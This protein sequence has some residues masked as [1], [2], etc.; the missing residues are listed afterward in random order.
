LAARPA[1]Y[2]PASL[3]T[4]PYASAP[5]T[6][7]HP[8]REMARGTTASEGFA[9]PAFCES[10]LKQTS[11]NPVD[12][13]Q[14]NAP[15]QEREPSVAR[16]N[17][18]RPLHAH[19]PLLTLTPGITASDREGASPWTTDNA[20]QA[21]TVTATTVSRGGSSVAPMAQIAR[22]VRESPD[23]RRVARD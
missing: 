22:L 20:V 11:G 2:D 5:Q 4:F 6:N 1:S 21:L 19:R 8:A 14:G 15:G 3:E 9:R 10:V 13:Q 18:P 23:I 17:Q 12:T 7:L 16:Q